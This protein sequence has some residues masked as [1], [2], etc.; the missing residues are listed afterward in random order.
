MLGDGR[1]EMIDADEWA[2]LKGEVHDDH[3]HL[4]IA[5]TLRS[6]SP[7]AALD[8]GLERGGVLGRLGPVGRGPAESL[9]R[10]LDLEHWAAF[11]DRSIV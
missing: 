6:C 11:Q 4:L 2:W 3:D 1:R 9:R 8:R 10:A 7:D 5:G